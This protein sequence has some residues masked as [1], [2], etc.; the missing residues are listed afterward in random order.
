MP[1]LLDVLT[2]LAVSHPH[3]GTGPALD[4]LLGL[5]RHHEQVA[6][7]LGALRRAVDQ[8]HDRAGILRRWRD[9]MG[10]DAYEE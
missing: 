10:C 6:R 9:I 3:L 8:S 4:D 5:Q 1:Y 7:E 2:R